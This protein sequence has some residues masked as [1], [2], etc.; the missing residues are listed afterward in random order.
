MLFIDEKTTVLMNRSDDANNPLQ[1]L[2]S[3]EIFSL[4]LGGS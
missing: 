3:V 4:M 1:T 2:A